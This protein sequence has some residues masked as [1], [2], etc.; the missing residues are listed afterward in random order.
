MAGD[1]GESFAYGVNHARDGD[2]RWCGSHMMAIGQ[3]AQYAVQQTISTMGSNL[4]IV[5]PVHSPHLACAAVQQVRPAQ[6]VRC[7]SNTG[8]DGVLTVAPT[9]WRGKAS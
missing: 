6:R 7:R 3:G 2:R 1:G 4:F 8:I 9:H 5:L